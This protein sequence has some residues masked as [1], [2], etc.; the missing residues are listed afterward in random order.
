MRESDW[1][2]LRSED[3][4]EIEPHEEDTVN[5]HPSI[6]IIIVVETIDIVKEELIATMDMVTS[7]VNRVIRWL[8]KP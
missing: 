2:I 4:F 1:Y 6:L 8:E 5:K 7:M 3:P